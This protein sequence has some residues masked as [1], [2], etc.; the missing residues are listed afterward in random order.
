MAGDSGLASQVFTLAKDLAKVEEAVKGLGER[1]STVQAALAGL[2]LGPIQLAIDHLEERTSGLQ[3]EVQALAPLEEGLI[4]LAKTVKQLRQDLEALA[5]KPDEEN[6]AVWNWSLNEGMDKQEAAEAWDVLVRWVR[7]ELQGT[8]GWV[9][10]P[11]DMFAKHNPTGYGSVSNGPMTAARIPPCWYRHRDAVK[12]LSWLCQEWIKI[13]RTSY[14]TPSR[15]GDWHDRYAPG[16]KRRVITA[17]TKCVEKSAHVDEPWVTDPN[18][19]GAPQA[20]DDDAVLSSYLEW[21]LQHRREPPAPGPVA[22]R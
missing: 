18:Q 16:V 2:D 13:Y 4:A 8:Y 7:S 1:G 20:T 6:L 22:D 11:A 10:W 9:G 3:T 19:P 5:A 15:A 21:D 14:G 17:L 12:E